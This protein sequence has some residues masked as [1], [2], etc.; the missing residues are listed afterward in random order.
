MAFPAIAAILLGGASVN[1]AS[2]VNV[3]VGTF[4][5]Q[6]ILT[7]TPSVINSVMQTDMSEVIRIIVSNGMIL[8]AL[9]RKVMV[10]R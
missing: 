7:M 2:M 3:V 4:L 6:G 10:K 9:T 5:F 1:K 8:Y